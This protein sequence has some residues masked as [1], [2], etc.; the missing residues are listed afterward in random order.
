[1]HV[2]MYE[3]ICM[4]VYVVCMYVCMYVLLTYVCMY[5]CMHVECVP[6]Q[7]TQQIWKQNLFLYLPL[8]YIFRP[9]TV[10]IGKNE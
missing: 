8:S 9:E 1:M 2:C 10:T 5:A 3:Y 6:A 4:C 7:P